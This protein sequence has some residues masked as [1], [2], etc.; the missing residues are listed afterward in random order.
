MPVNT[1]LLSIV[2]SEDIHKDVAH[3]F[4]TE[5]PALRKQY[6]IKTRSIVA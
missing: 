6:T 1:H 4:K 3:Y 2:G 5:F